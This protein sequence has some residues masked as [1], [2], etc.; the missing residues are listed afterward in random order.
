M[1]SPT[2]NGKELTMTQ[3]EQVQLATE[4]VTHWRG[5]VER[6]ASL[7]HKWEKQL[8]TL[9]AKGAKPVEPTAAKLPP[10]AL[11]GKVVP[12]DAAKAKGKKTPPKPKK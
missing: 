10:L 9:K 4:K 1:V 11:D 3:I 8:A 5:K 6:A 2:K 12:I 7:L